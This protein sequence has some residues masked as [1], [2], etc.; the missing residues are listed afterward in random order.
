[1][2]FT[3]E[4]RKRRLS[5]GAQQRIARALGVRESYVSAAMRDEVHPKTPKSWAK[6]RRVQDAIAADLGAPVAEVFDQTQQ[7]APPQT[8][9]E[10]S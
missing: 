10:A 1:M 4:D 7:E 3:F 2:P 5:F 9:A 8:M 6:L